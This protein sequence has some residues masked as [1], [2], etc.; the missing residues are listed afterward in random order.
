MKTIFLTLIL[1]GF[2]FTAYNQEPVSV[3]KKFIDRFTLRQS[4][5]SSNSKAE[6]AQL[7]FT[8]P[9][10]KDEAWLLNAA[11]GFSILENTN[12]N[13]TLDPYVEFNKNTLIAKVQDNWQAGFTT[14]WQSLDLEFHNW[15]PIFIATTKYNEDRIKLNTSFQGNIYFTPIFTLKPLPKYFWIPNN[16]IEFKKLFSFSYTPYIGFEN[17]NRIKTPEESSSGNIYRAFFRVTSNI[18]LAPKAQKQFELNFDWQYRNNFSESVSDLNTREHKFFTTSFNYIFY[19]EGNKSAKI[20]IDYTTGDNPTKNFEQQ[21]FYAVT[22][23]V[24]L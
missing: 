13:L 8:K 3:K 22:L 20:G 6:P 14:Q 18:L 1:I 2:A 17:E 23:K 5:Q 12:L 4:F 24:K 15:S 7:T 16:T 9:K 19:K 21:S 10:D 11:I